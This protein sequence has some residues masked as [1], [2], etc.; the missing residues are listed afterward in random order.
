MF[1]PWDG[2]GTAPGMGPGLG[3]AHVLSGRAAGPGPGR[4]LGSPP[5]ERVGPARAR[6]HARGWAWPGPCILVHII[7]YYCILINTSRDK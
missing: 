1:L 5:A 3:R 4:A 2:P 7:I 6:A